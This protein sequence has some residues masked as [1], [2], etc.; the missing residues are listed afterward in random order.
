MILATLN[1]LY[2]V[3]GEE[4]KREIQ[5][6]KHVIISFENIVALGKSTVKELREYV[7]LPN[8]ELVHLTDYARGQL[9]IDSATR[10]GWQ[11]SLF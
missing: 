9:E 10:S 1:D 8:V 5:K 3:Q 6:G 11:M 2:M 4:I 7:N